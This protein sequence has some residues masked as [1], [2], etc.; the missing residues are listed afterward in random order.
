M[1][2]DY[3]SPPLLCGI[4]LIGAMIYVAAGLILSIAGMTLLFGLLL[5]PLVANVLAL[6]ALGYVAYDVNTSIEAQR[7]DEITVELN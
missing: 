4:I 7:A 3:V 5:N 6:L 1:L 2:T